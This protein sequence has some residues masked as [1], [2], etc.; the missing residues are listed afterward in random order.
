M[1]FGKKV[2]PKG[3]FPKQRS[4]G[5]F[6]NDNLSPNL[7][8]YAKKIADDMHFTLIISG[9]DSVGNGK[10]TLATQIASYLT[11]KINELH[12]TNN[13]FQNNNV[14]WKARSLID[15]SFE[16]PKLSVILLDEGDDL[17]EH[18]MKDT[19]RELKRYFRKCRQLNQILIL[20]LP[21]FFELPKFYALARSHCLINVKF[22]GEFERGVFDF[23][24]PSSKKLL[25]LKGKR[26]W[27]YSVAPRDFDGNFFG[28]YAFFP[29]CKK[30]TELY[31]IKKHE[32]I[33]QDGDEDLSV[34][35]QLLYQKIDFF[36]KLH[37]AFPNI[38][39]KDMS[40]AFGISSSRATEYLKEN[41][42][43]SKSTQTQKPDFGHTYN[44]ILVK[45][46][47]VGGSTE[48]LP[49]KIKEVLNEVKD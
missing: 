1:K 19:A 15:R 3:T 11:L 12:G 45:D 38:L 35:K 26:E 14:V 22:H 17:T 37:A 30:E 6:L 41:F 5:G 9:N 8:V 18:G 27:N 39:I 2:W 21:S 10:S 20:I 23:Y 34:S 43:I 48:P 31:H 28:S 16:L 25:Y 47:D 49:I 29:D 40:K 32:D 44:N 4:D 7:D 42:A 24:G 13:K 33:L 36:R 46:D